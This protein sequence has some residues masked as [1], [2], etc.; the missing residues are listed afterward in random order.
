MVNTRKSHSE[1]GRPGWRGHVTARPVHG[2]PTDRRKTWQLSRQRTE[3]LA[4]VIHL[5]GAGPANASARRGFHLLP[6]ERCGD[7][8]V[9][10]YLA[11]ID[12]MKQKFL[13]LASER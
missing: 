6:S 1:T 10:A 9:A 3:Q 5:C 11:E 2:L 13:G 7:H 4:A 12:A 8:D